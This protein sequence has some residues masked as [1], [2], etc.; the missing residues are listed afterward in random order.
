M[1]TL[2]VSPI[3]KSYVCSSSSLSVH[4]YSKFQISPRLI[5]FDSLPLTVEEWTLALT[6]FFRGIFARYLLVS[7]T[8]RPV[9]IVQDILWSDAFHIGLSQA[10]LSNLRVCALCFVLACFSAK[11]PA[12]S[13]IPNSLLTIYS[14]RLSSGFV[15]DC[16][17]TETR[18]FPI[19]ASP[20][21]G[22]RLCRLSCV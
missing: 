5:P 10:L 2:I 7:P 3:T 6:D 21:E 8:E 12:L 11:V 1:P 20:P 16:G 14:T 4:S 9:L 22:D 19:S 17:Y 18:F 13:F 15:I